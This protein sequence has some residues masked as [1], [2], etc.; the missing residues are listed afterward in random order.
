VS[1]L[2]LLVLVL[3]ARAALAQVVPEREVEVSRTLYDNG[4][5]AEALKRANDAM[6]RSN[7]TDA[8][9]LTLHELAAL[10]AFNLGD[11]KASQK[12]F[13]QL[14]QLDPDHQLD[15]FAVAPAAI[16]VFEQVRRDNADSLNLVRQQLALRA[17]QTRRETA[18]RERALKEQ[19]ERRRRVEELARTVT[20]RTVEKRPFLV[21]FIPFGAGQF[22]EGRVGP[23]VAFAVI[24]AVMGITSV[25]SYFAINALYESYTFTLNDRINPDGTNTYTGTVKRIPDARK[26]DYQVWSALKFATGGAFYLGWALGI[27]DAIWHH[28]G[29]VTVETQQ[30]LPPA[31]AP[32][33]KVQLDLFPTPGGLGGGLTIGF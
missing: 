30:Q 19:E 2:A 28:L 24:E 6:E 29:E 7:F 1:R 14:L 11:V 10:S 18:D 4:K 3:C 8:Q 26:T 31:S 17:E 27:V 15:P 21:N 23:G 32:G 5:Y 20:V 9:R 33:P 16:K 12:H 13:L 25:I 22:Q